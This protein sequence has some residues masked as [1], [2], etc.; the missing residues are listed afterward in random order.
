[1]SSTLLHICRETEGAPDAGADFE[2]GTRWVCECGLNYVFHEGFNRG[3]G[4]TP[5]WFVAPPLP[6]PRGPVGTLLFG[7]RKG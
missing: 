1:M 4:Y 3:G 2:V 7:P 5:S 6:K